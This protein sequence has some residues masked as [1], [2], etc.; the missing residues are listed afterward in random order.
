MRGKTMADTRSNSVPLQVVL[1]EELKEIK[2]IR[3]N[4]GNKSASS[5]RHGKPQK[6][7]ELAPTPPI[8]AVP[9]EWPEK[10]PDWVEAVREAHATNLVG[11]A[12]SGGGIRSATFNL[13]VLQALADLKLLY[14]IDYLSTV[15][16]GGYIGGWL[17][18]WT[19]RAKDG[20]KEVQNALATNRVHQEDDKEPTPIRFLRVFSNYLTPKL[21]IFSG[22]TWAATAILLRNMLLNQ[23]VV[24]ALLSALLLIPRAVEKFALAARSAPGLGPTWMHW[25]A[26]LL[27]LAFFTILNN[28]AA[29]DLGD[30]GGAWQLTKQG[31]VLALAGAP[32]FA[33]AA[34]GALWQVARFQ[35][36]ESGRLPY[37]TAALVGAG[38]YGTIWL[39]ATLLGLAYRRFLA[40]PI[41]VIALKWA[42]FRGE[43]RKGPERHH[44]TTSA[45]DR[46]RKLSEFPFTW[47]AAIAAGAFAGGL[48]ALLSD[49]MSRHMSDALTYGVPL[50]VGIFLLAGTLHIGLMGRDFPDR[51][52]EWWGRLGG[53]LLVWGLAWL[54]IFWVAL[55]FPAFI[56]TNPLAKKAAAKYLTPVWIATTLGGAWAGRSKASGKPGTLAWQDVVAKVAPYVF[57]VG[58]MCWIS[59]EINRIQG[60]KLLADQGFIADRRLWLAI[61]GCLAL[62]LFM[63]WRVD[64]NQFSMHMFYRN[65][66]VKAYL[67]A[68]N[69]NRSPNRFTGFDLKD[70]IHL[71]DFSVKHNKSYDGPYPIF[72]ASLNLVKG[73]DLAW[74]ERKAE[75]FVMT[76][77]YCGYDVWL[78]DQ[79]TP[80][81]RGE[82]PLTVEEAKQREANLTAWQRW[83]NPLELYGYRPTEEYAFPPPDYGPDLGLAM[84]ISGAAASP[85]MG[86]YTSIPVAFLMTIFN[87]RLGQWLGNPRHRKTSR[88]ASPKLGLSY[89]VNEL[90]A[91]TDD[92][93]AYVYLSDGGH[94]EN[95]GIYELV[96]RRC[97]LIIVCDAEADDQYRF[98]GLGNAIRKCRI[99]LGIDIVLDVSDIKPKKLGKPS[100]KHYAVGKIHYEN[101]DYPNEKPDEKPDRP[102]VPTGTI[103]YFKAS[104]TGNEPADLKN[105]AKTHDTFPHES[106]VDQ[107]FSESQFESYR[108]LGYHAVTSSIPNLIRPMG[109]EAASVSPGSAAPPA[110]SEPPDTSAL[111]VVKDCVVRAETELIEM[112]RSGSKT[113]DADTKEDVPVMKWKETFTD[114]GFDFS[115]L[116]DDT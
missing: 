17:A 28:M 74:Q 64:V 85:N 58:L 107:W 111:L 61:A 11:L 43:N 68:S 59:W 9:P 48:Y 115:N 101:V 76:P 53:S 96:K 90:S 34:L 87:V 105:Y 23:V 114:F 69:L 79:D 19:M 94:F 100:K 46:L 99:D 42:A 50:V 66:L 39:A 45:K 35:Q 60:W 31:W 16:G 81:V 103:I 33:T 106:T 13:G 108:V 25:A 89:L 41:S 78:E 20:F 8:S 116:K 27:L 83:W 14:R 73:Q 95:M 52:R 6:E 91:G 88:R 84:G 62:A 82:R 55:Y 65:R 109:L 32:L 44:K 77:R 102:N 1:A 54:A 3:E 86:F 37:L 80:I 24:L 75:S 10:D 93:A 15:S 26:V 22:D 4:R 112:E 98:E 71:K 63:A 21:G 30:S 2:K 67:G 51:Y 47:I 57:V 7:A 49:H 40:F 72:N 104:L 38:A 97:G 12:F 18:A 5:C 70:D 36:G 56:Q 110:S 92:K 113:D 29:L